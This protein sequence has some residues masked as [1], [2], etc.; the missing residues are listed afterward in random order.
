MQ[1]FLFCKKK[2][3]YKP[4]THSKYSVIGILLLSIPI[5]ALMSLML[6]Y[7][8]F[9][10]PQIYTAFQT[11]QGS[12]TDFILIEQR[13]PRAVIAPIVGACLGLSGVLVQNLSRNPL[14]SPGIL[15]INAGAAFA[16]VMAVT[17]FSITSLA[18]LSWFALMGAL[19]SASVVYGLSLLGQQTMSSLRVVLI[20]TALTALFSALTNT[21]LILD[22]AALD[23]LLF[24]LAG[25]VQ[26]R[27]L[28]MLVSALPF[29]VVGGII[30]LYVMNHLDLS[31]LGDHAAQALGQK[32]L[33][34]KTLTFVAV[35]LLA[36]ACVTI[37]GPIGFIGL[38]VPHISRQLVGIRTRMSLLVSALLG[39]N[40]LL[41]ADIACRF[42]IFP[43][44]APVGIVTAFMGA[45][46]F[47]YL[48]YK[49]I[50]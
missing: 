19:L 46:F 10:L 42:I 47:I 44:E 41:L 28:D 43:S 39:A 48:T 20:G 18:W 12:D 32:T 8:Y 14:A 33:H 5:L 40:L 11:F 31:A 6:G 2:I 3:I 37:A 15:G 36:S 30:M 24:W 25:S 29:L 38:I 1:I 7:H 35:A 50:T 26:G 21:A 17:F 49:S 13:W 16:V 45:P 34:I 9:S 23:Q 22:E 4:M 27:S